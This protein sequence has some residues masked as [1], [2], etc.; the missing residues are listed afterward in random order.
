MVYQPTLAQAYYAS[1]SKSFQPS[2]ESFPLA[3]NNAQIAPEQTTSHEVGAK[4]DFLDGF[5]TATAS[6]FRLERTNIKATNPATNTLIPIGMQRT[7]GLEL[8]VSGQ[9]PQGWQVY[10]GYAL[11]DARVISSVAVDSGQPV[12]GKRATL[13]PMHSANLWLTKA[14]GGGFGAGG[15]F[16]Y[17][18]DRSANPGNTV[19]LPNYVTFDAVAYWRARGYDLQ[20]N[21]FNLFD[22]KYIVAGHGSAPNLNLPGAPRSA[23]VTLRYA[24]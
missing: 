21:V 4:L 22:R 23:Q 6:L 18:G 11:L 8:T 19:T 2:A 12:Q 9:L 17:V 5:A 10:S 24:F 15:G 14:L 16:N 7:D 20:L 13:T 3:A 1:Y